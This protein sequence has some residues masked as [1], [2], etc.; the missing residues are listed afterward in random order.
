MRFDAAVIATDAVNRHAMQFALSGLIGTIERQLGASLESG[1]PVGMPINVSHDKHWL[2]GWALPKGVYVAKDMA[3]QVALML[4]AETQAEWERVDAMRQAFVA[5]RDRQAVDPHLA[6]LRGRVGP[7]VPGE[8]QAKGC[9]AAAI[10]SA[11]L[12]ANAY[13][14]FF[15]A[16]GHVD[17]DGLV[18]VDFLLARTRQVEPGVFHEPVRDLILFAHPYFR[19]SQSRDNSLNAYVMR[20]FFE[21]AGDA[22]VRSRLRLDPDMLGHPKSVRPLM[23]LEWWN[24]PR[25]DDAI[26]TIPSGVTEHKSSD[27][28]RTYAQI[29]KTQ[30]W[31]KEPERRHANLIRT[32][33]IEELVEQPSAGLGDNIFGCRYAH[34]EYDVAS[35]TVSHFDGAIRAYGAEAYLKRIDRR[36]DRAGKHSDYN[37]LFRLDGAL[38]VPVWKRILS[39]FYRG[40]S[41]VPEYLGAPPEEDALAQAHAAESERPALA[42][43]L[44]CEIAACAAPEQV[45]ISS[46]QSIEIGGQSFAYIDA[47]PGALGDLLAGWI[48][49]D[50]VGKMRWTTTI[51]N[52][53]PILLPGDPPS[54]SVWDATVA[55]LVL[56]LRDADTESQPRTI[57]V[58]L[59]WF[60]KGLARSLSIAGT[61]ELV[62]DFLARSVAIVRPD[63]PSSEWVEDLQG[64][65]DEVAP[66]LVAAV[67][68]PESVVKL[69]RI[70]LDR[71][72][73]KATFQFPGSVDLSAFAIDAGSDNRGTKC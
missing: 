4:Q 69:G 20:S 1:A 66:D 60:V 14:E 22:S 3:R 5:D 62:G 70:D 33:E 68:W 8:V 61:T 36:I 9:E 6:E 19:R 52:I 51:S 40:N 56:A 43:Y 7:C 12:A 72:D 49:D 53:A 17:K 23:E 37:K 45:C 48:D 28:E 13:P 38:P 67:D 24:G 50:T 44:G 47:V 29:D 57:S 11:G 42:F 32:F 2:I 35:G 46:D 15:A 54:Q 55:D 27:R 39:D 30:I 65:L 10:V 21:A 71:E 63:R 73:E 64:L 18:D 34:A 31:W 25:Y 58:T 41:L 26:G 59:R 16:G